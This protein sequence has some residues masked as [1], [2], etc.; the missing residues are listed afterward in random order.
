MEIAPRI[1]ADE[2]VRFG[3]PVVKGTR[4][5]VDLILGKLAG[6]MTYEDVMV[7]YDLARED[8]LAA[9]NYA[10]KSL[11]EEKIRSIG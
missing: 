11:S 3:K 6:G 8:I 2:K 9:L 1:T 7:E 5:P 4:V 10:A